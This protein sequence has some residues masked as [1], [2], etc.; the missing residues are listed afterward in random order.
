MRFLSV[1]LAVGAALFSV[2]AGAQQVTGKWDLT[3]DT[4]NGPFALVFDLAADGA[5]KLT[6]SLQN[7][8]IGSIPIKEGTIKGNE[9]AFKVSIEG[10]PDGTINISYTGVVKGDE[11][12]LTSKIEGA[13]PGGGPAEQTATATRQ[14]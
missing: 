9:V 2:S 12:V 11:L 3:V 4:A 6:G 7:E 13:P 5:G 10:A 1:V 8:F 14:K